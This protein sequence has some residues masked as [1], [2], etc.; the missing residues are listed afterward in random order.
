MPP[1]KPERVWDNQDVFIIGGGGS[2]E[3]FDWSL[4]K[5]KLTIG[6]ND[7]Y[8]HGKDICKICIFG[9]TKWF[10]KHKPQLAQYKGVV[11]TNAPKLYKSKVEWLWVMQR[12]SSGLHEKALGWN[13]STGAAAVNLAL[14]LGAKR[15]LLL[16]FDM[17]LARNGKPNWHQNN[18]D[19]PNPEVYLKFVR[20]F[21]R[22][23]SDLKRK[24]P[25]VEVINVTDNSN[26]DVFP[27]V[28]VEDFWKGK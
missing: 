22:V 3:K 25:D 21:E 1:W 10:G 2:L 15:V 26:L 5:D 17:Q 16:G 24:Y 8:L 27:K 11:F 6:C 19:K 7:A 4:L 13:F 20:G 28:G 23:A 9:D 14:L 18:L 12:N